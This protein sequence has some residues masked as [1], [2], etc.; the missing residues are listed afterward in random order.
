MLS[1]KIVDCVCN[2]I[3]NH[4]DCCSFTIFGNKFRCD[5]FIDVMWDWNCSIKITD[6]GVYFAFQWKSHIWKKILKED[7]TLE[8]SLLGDSSLTMAGRYSEVQ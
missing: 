1:N 2:K 8:T 4:S 5:D 7:Q 3:K 6:Y